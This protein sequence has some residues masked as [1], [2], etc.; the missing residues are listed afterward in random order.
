[1]GVDG[2]CYTPAALPPFPGKS[3]GTHWRRLGGPPLPEWM[4]FDKDK[5]PCLHWRSNCG[6]SGS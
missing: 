3:P 5:I 6:P 2:E 1:M 4:V